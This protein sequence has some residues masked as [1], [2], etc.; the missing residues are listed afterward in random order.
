MESVSA[1]PTVNSGYAYELIH[2]GAARTRPA[3]VVYRAYWGRTHLLL[4]LLLLVLPFIGRF[5]TWTVLIDHTTTS[6]C[7]GSRT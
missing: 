3:Y 4:L 7:G 2:Q 5:S 1:P 6:S